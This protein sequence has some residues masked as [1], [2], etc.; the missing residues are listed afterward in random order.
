MK[1]H[2]FLPAEWVTVSEDLKLRLAPEWKEIERARGEIETFLRARK[3]SSDSLQAVAMVVCELLE[4][5]LKYGRFHPGDVALAV[6]ITAGR[7][8]VE[9]VNSFGEEARP[10]LRRLDRTIQ[11]IRGFQDPFQAL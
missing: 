3:V 1:G 5:S 2:R 7:V 8:T 11:W 6:D 10:H 9:V 4:N